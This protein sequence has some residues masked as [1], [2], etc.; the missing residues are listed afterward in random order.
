MST[1]R[2]EVAKIDEV[3]EHPNA[4]RLKIAIIKGWRTAIR[5]DPDA[6]TSQFNKGD[7]CVFF[8]PDSMISND[9]A[10]SL[11][12]KNFTAQV[13]DAK[14]RIVACRIR[15]EV[16]FGFIAKPPSGVK[17]GDDLTSYYN[18]EKW[19]MPENYLKDDYCENIPGFLEYTDI[20]NW[21]NYPNAFSNGD[22]IV[23]TE[24]I[25]G[26][27]CRYANQSILSRSVF[28]FNIMSIVCCY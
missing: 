26:F 24:K 22:N 27:T 16:S 2:I 14:C 25:D 1:M 13:S 28:L 12:V 21:G 18:A 19:N 5:Y 11:G 10:E 9:L 3:L 23:I 20:E 4:D 8:P 6:K 7:L 17:L 15:G